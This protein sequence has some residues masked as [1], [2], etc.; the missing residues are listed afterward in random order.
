VQ[1]YQ[2]SESHISAQWYS[3][4]L[5][6]VLL[7][8]KEIFRVTWN[9]TLRQNCG[10]MEMVRCRASGKTSCSSQ[11]L[12]Y[13]CPLARNM[14]RNHK[15]TV[16]QCYV[17]PSVFFHHLPVAVSRYL[18]IVA[19]RMRVF[20]LEFS[21]E[22]ALGFSLVFALFFTSICTRFSLVFALEFSLVFTLVKSLY[23]HWDFHSYL[24][25]NSYS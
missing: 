12:V 15:Q 1:V 10:A 7:C 11:P 3:A 19:E 4:T 14:A 17:V 20:A 25:T 8:G 24:H 18:A 23:L 22:L 16:T 21:L 13:V 9:V 2:S 5:W 6:L